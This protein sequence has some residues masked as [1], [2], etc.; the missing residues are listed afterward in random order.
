MGLETRDNVTIPAPLLSAAI[1]VS[2]ALFLLGGHTSWPTD[3][4]ASASAF[5]ASC[6]HAGFFCSLPAPAAL[7]HSTISLLHCCL[8][9]M[10]FQFSSPERAVFFP[11]YYLS[12]R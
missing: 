10:G 7:W 1:A 6:C 8:D 2:V 4:V 12:P 3:D 11:V 9:A 5:V